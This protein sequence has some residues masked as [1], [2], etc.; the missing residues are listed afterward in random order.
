[1]KIFKQKSKKNIQITDEH[2]VL[3]S[4]QISLLIGK[5]H[6]R[7]KSVEINKNIE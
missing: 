6:S 2:Y 1:M 7:E 3:A 5:I 4:L